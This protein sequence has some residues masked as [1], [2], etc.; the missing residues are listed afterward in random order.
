MPTQEVLN[1]WEA[2][3]PTTKSEGPLQG[4]SNPPQ[5]LVSKH[6]CFAAQP[7]AEVCPTYDDGRLALDQDRVRNSGARTPGS[8]HAD[9]VAQIEAKR[10]RKASEEAK[11][12]KKKST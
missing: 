10:E 4:T 2:S 12:D 3:S 8:I 5:S 9:I 7:N 11:K 6:E 1:Q